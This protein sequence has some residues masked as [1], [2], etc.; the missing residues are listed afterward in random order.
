M[1]ALPCRSHALFA[2]PVPTDRAV[3]R[4]HASLQTEYSVQQRKLHKRIIMLI[5]QQ[6]TCARLRGLVRNLIRNQSLREDLMQEGMIHLWHEELANPGHTE[7]WYIQNCRFWVLNYLK[8]GR[9]VDLGTHRREQCLAAKGACD[10]CDEHLETPFEFTSTRD[11]VSALSTRLPA[12]EKE[13]LS[14][15]AEGFGPSD[16]AVR[17]HISHQAVSKH[18]K[19][20]A[21]LAT[22]LGIASPTRSSTDTKC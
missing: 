7:S 4:A 19:H 8:R 14:Y 12:A 1:N 13:I 17:L 16:I 22:Q 5:D 20:I 3:V 6:K 9:S 10:A 21:R 18:R 11:I 2:R 15:L